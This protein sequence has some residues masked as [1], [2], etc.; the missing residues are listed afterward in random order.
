MAKKIIKHDEIVVRFG[1]K[2][3]EL[4]LACGMSQAELATQSQVTTNYISRLEAGRAA[5]GIDLAARLATALGVTISDLLP[6]PIPP[7]ED[8]AVMR[9]QAQRLFELLVKTQD[10]AVLSLLTQLLARL[11]EATNR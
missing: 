3:R 9:Q 1:Q 11:S 6:M 2:L 10:R 7:M 5:P 4:R 8:L